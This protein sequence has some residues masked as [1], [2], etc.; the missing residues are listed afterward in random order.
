MGWKTAVK[1][2]IGRRKAKGRLSFKME[3]ALRDGKEWCGMERGVGRRRA[4][5]FLG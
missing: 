2:G 4:K 1:M 5:I 3:G